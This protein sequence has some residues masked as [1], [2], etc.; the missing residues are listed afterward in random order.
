MKYLLV[1]PSLPLKVARCLHALLHLEPLELE[2]V[3]GGIDRKHESEIL[4][5]SLSRKP[6]KDFI[7]ALRRFSPDVI[8]FTAYSNQAKNVLELAKLAKQELDDVINM[9]G[10]HGD[11]S[12]GVFSGMRRD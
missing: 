9:G 12:S 6:E 1:K 7:C 5:L 2:I 3:A 4:D 10:V 8:G 11:Y